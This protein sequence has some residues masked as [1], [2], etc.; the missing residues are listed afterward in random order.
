M[1]GLPQKYRTGLSI[2][3]K[4]QEIIKLQHFKRK[5]EHPKFLGITMLRAAANAEQIGDT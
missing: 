4:V 1:C 2:S 3:L 5:N